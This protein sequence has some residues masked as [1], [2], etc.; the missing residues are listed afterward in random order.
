MTRRICIRLDEKTI[1][2][3]SDVCKD[4]GE[5][6]SDFVRRAIRTDLAKRGYLSRKEMKALEVYIK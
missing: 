2:V 4:R 3:A 6:F 5:N 1:K